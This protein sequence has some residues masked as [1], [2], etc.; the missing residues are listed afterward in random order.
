M[1]NY[2]TG[3][4]TICPFYLREAEKSIACEGLTPGTCCLTRFAGKEEKEQFQA[5]CCQGF[6]YAERCPLAAALM[7]KY[8]KA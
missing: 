7:E 8:D 4:S 3:A 2:R 5:E 6:E 1:A